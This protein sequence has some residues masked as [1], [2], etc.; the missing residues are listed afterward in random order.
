MLPIGVKNSARIVLS[1]RVKSMSVATFATLAGVAGGLVFGIVAA[2]AMP[3]L[4]FP[5][6]TLPLAVGGTCGVVAAALMLRRPGGQRPR[7]G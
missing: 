2:L 5:E 7:A 6:L 4:G 1:S 3:A